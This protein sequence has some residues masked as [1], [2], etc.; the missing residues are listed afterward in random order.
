MRDGPSDQAT[1]HSV[2]D[3]SNDGPSPGQSVRHAY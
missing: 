2:L 3:K 1:G